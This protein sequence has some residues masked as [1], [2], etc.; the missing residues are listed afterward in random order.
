MKLTA[1][2]ARD[3][4]YDDAKDWAMVTGTLEIDGNG[5]WSI[6]KTA[7]FLH[8]PSK[9]HYSMSWSVGATESQDERAFEY[10]EPEPIEVH[11]VEKTVTIWEPV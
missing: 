6:Y 1:N 2:E 7:V 9:K 11:Q 8:E 5:R 4:V 10:T 3:I